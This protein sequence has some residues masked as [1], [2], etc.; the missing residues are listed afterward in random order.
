MG[1]GEAARREYGLR[2]RAVGVA[3]RR[4][5]GYLDVIMEAFAITSSYNVLES[6]VL[7]LHPRGKGP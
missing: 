7:E 3:A 2:R 4:E 1:L 6:S 5:Y